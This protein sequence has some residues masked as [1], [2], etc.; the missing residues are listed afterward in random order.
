MK[1]DQRNASTIPMLDYSIDITVR[2][3]I[4]FCLT[5]VHCILTMHGLLIPFIQKSLH[6]LL[7]VCKLY[8]IRAL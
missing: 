8:I 7:L 3:I 4:K 6:F 5:I 2:N 1:C